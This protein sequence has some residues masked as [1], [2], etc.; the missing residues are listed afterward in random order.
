M[1]IEEFIEEFKNFIGE[2]EYLYW[3]KITN[4]TEESV[5]EYAFDGVKNGYSLE[6]QL[7]ISKQI[8]RG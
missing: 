2:E 4:E 6:E 3:L 5:K 8:V 1:N 7:E